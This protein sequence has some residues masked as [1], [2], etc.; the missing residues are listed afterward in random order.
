MPPGTAFDAICERLKVSVRV[1]AE[2]DD[3]AMIRLLARD[4]EAVALLPAIVVRDELNS[5]VLRELGVVPGLYE[6]FYAIRPSV[7]IRTRY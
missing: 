6:E 5:G 3:M 4:T 2:I 1:L 7:G